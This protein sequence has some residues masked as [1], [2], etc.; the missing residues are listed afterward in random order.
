[1][2][3]VAA[4]S[5]AAS[6]PERARRKQAGRRRPEPG[7]FSQ[8]CCCRLVVAA[9]AAAATRAALHEACAGVLACSRARV[10]PGRP[11]YSQS[12]VNSSSAC[13]P[14]TQGNVRRDK[15][16]E[17]AAAALLIGRWVLGRAAAASAATAGSPL[18]IQWLVYKLLPPP[19][20]PASCLLLG[21]SPP[22]PS[23]VSLALLPAKGIK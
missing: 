19:P 12:K 5:Q 16:R 21:Q 7:P 22:C 23:F 9:A 6:Q 13:E 20:P 18:C 2:S 15:G 11:G 1:V 8:C 10:Q 3:R 4:C 14:S 17:T